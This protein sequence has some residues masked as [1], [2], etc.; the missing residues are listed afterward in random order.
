[1]N[2][3]ELESLQAKSKRI[4]DEMERLTNENEQLKKQQKR[5]NYELE[6]KSFDISRFKDSDKDIEFYTGL[7]HWDALMLVFNML[8]S[9]AQ[10]LN[11]GSYTKKEVHSGKKLGRPRSISKFD[12][13]VLTLIRLR[14]GLLQ[15]DLSHRFNSSEATVSRVFQTWVRFMRVELE[16]LIRLPSKEMLHQ[17]M[18]NIFK[19]LYP[20]TVLIIDAVEIRAESPSSLDMQSACYS[21]YKGT[22]TMK[23]LVG[24][25][26]VG[27]LGFLSEFFT[28]SISDRE[29]TNRCGIIDHLNPGD[30]VI[31]DKGFE[32][33]DDFAKKGVTINIP[34]FLKGKVQFS[35]EEVEHNKKIASLRIHVERC[36]ERIKNWHVFDSRIPITLA[37]VASDM[38]ITVGALT[39]FLP[40]LI[41]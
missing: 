7:P 27:A 2:G 31:A 19:E 9:K 15:R 13:F 3:E 17:F 26:P 38:F 1:M 33:Q 16:P 40:P 39:N 6:N 5:L 22:T 37:P 32:V 25:S 34:S 29:L 12:E 24:L 28:G 8:Y 18:P 41:D 36:I 35:R 20:K 14:L 21:S 4:S 10:N 11:Y 23:A 30:D